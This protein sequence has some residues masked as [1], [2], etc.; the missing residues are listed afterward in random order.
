MMRNKRNVP[1]P[2]ISAE[3]LKTLIQ[4]ASPEETSDLSPAEIDQVVAQILPMLP[5]GNIPQM[6]FS[7]LARLRGR[8][9][10]EEKIHRDLNLILRGMENTLDK[11]AFLGFFGGPAAAIWMYQGF[12][13]LAGI[14]VADAFPE[15]AWQFYVNYAL[16]EDTARHANET[17][18]FD[19]LLK[20][21]DIHLDRV[22]RMTSWVM[23]AI[24][25]LHQYDDML[26]NE[27]RERVYT[28]V[29]REVTRNLPEADFYAGLYRKW[30]ELRPYSRGSDALDE[31]TYPIYR[32][33]R[34][35]RFLKRAMRELPPDLYAKWKRRVQS[36]EAEH[37]PLYQQQMSILAY[38]SPGVYYEKR[39]RIPIER[40]HIGVIYEGNYYL[41]PACEPGTKLGT[42]LETV[43]NRVA[44]IV[45]GKTPPG[46]VSLQGLARVKRSAASEVRRGLSQPV[47][48]ALHALRLAPIL[49]N[50]NTP[51]GDA[52]LGAVRQRERGAGDHPLTILDNGESMVFDQSHIFFDGAWGAALAEIMTNEALSW[53]VYLH[54]FPP[55]SLSPVAPRRLH[56]D[57]QP[58]DLKVI[59]A[60]PRSAAEACAETEAV[61]IR[62]IYL[63][64]RL[65]KR[66]S[67]LLRLT[68][69]DLLVLYR[70]IHAVTYRPSPELLERI[71]ALEADPRTRQAGRAAR[72]AVEPGQKVNPSVLIPVDASLC[73]PTERVHPLS[74]EAPLAQLDLLNLH[75]QTIAALDALERGRD[76]RRGAY[77]EFDRLQRVYLV[78]LAGFGE[79]LS[80]AKEVAVSGKSSSIGSLKLL[81][82]L[83]A[84]LQHLLDA[85]STR[86]EW[87]NDMIRGREVFSNIGKVAYTS[88]LR[89]FLT[90][91]DD[92]AHKHFAWGIL[93]DK[94]DV[95]RITLRDFRPHVRELGA[96]GCKDVADAIA[97]DYLEAYAHGLNRYIAEVHRITIASRETKLSLKEAARRR[98][99]ARRAAQERR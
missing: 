55:Q 78:T 45:G 39:E 73:S 7:G 11:A 28:C 56:F 18:G 66:R 83:P 63:L 21:H 19:T 86:F 79:L 85:Y 41:I 50:F 67:D 77:A 25:C 22:E 64:R 1:A 68:V 70:A 35:K 36:L 96:V 52:P 5:A 62:A 75:R 10:P 26:A 37:L 44:A 30:F 8:K 6:I 23:A 88:T 32:H 43:I 98:L 74:F 9:L 65:F 4:S 80:R 82:H 93:T 34:F 89:R 94:D 58:R 54:T 16:R 95:M 46:T 57:F 12:L 51:T 97:Q 48:D 24:S 2:S 69:N 29:L 20:Q 3:E 14:R 27:W 61:N 49:L 17:H 53:A 90:A 72:K 59:A 42:H 15:G 47:Q 33:N 13:K 38:L 84:P 91:K 87:M 31:E 76:G 40:A 71:A 99:R 81:A 60:A 92:N